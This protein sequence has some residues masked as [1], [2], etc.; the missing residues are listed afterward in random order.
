MASTA[1]LEATV[2]LD[3]VD[4]DLRTIGRDLAGHLD[5][6]VGADQRALGKADGALGSEGA[7]GGFDTGGLGLVIG[8]KPQCSEHDMRSE[9]GRCLHGVRPSLDFIFVRVK[10]LSCN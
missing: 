2:K 4:I 9:L 1:A 10:Q 7:A 5:G 6:A 8:N 3:L